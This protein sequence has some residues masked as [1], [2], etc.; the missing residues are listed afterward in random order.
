MKL[1]AAKKICRNI[2]NNKRFYPAETQNRALKKYIPYLRKR[3]AK[4]NKELRKQ[5][6]PVIYAPYIMAEMV[7]LVGNGA[8]IKKISSRYAKINIDPSLYSEIEYE[9]FI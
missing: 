4:I 7:P 8:S 9:K 2:Y 3:C 5:G 1:R 6:S